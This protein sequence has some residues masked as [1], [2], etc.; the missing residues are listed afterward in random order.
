MNQRKI[1]VLI[2]ILL[3]AGSLPL[4]W[5]LSGGSTIQENEDNGVEVVHVPVS[6]FTPKKITAR[7]EFTGRVIPLEQID[8]SSEVVGRLERGSKRFKSGIQYQKGEPIIRIN[9]SEQ[10]EQLKARKYEFSALLSRILPDIGIDYPEAH[11]KWQNY[12]EQFDADTPLQPLPETDNRQLR[13]YLNSQNV[14]S[15]F[16]N[17]KQQEILLN[18]FTIRAP[19]TGVVT[20]S[21]VDPGDMIQPSQLLGEFTRLK[22]LEIEAGI[23]ADQIKYINEGDSVTMHLSERRRVGNTV[24]GLVDR[25]NA[26]IND[27]TQSVTVYIQVEEPTL[28]PGAYMEGTIDGNTFNNVYKISSDALVRHNSIFQIVDSTAVMREVNIL[29]H[30]GDS[31]I[32]DGLQPGAQIV[33][34]FR[35]AAFEG[36]KVAPLGNQ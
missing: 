20:E 7:I 16:H 25:I 23:P 21:R 3:L 22:P 2:G 15:T 13:L 27:N 11:K 19:F 14:Y 6:E 32:I 31:L 30:S 35:D 24:V 12:L 18:K 8:I 5:Y 28:K 9:N 34:E 33:D 29:A 17:I 36:T 26:K 10:K 4:A 1:S